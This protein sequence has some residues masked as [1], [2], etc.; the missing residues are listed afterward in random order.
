MSPNTKD[1]KK[2]PDL[3]NPGQM[4]EARKAFYTFSI[5]ELWVEMT[6]PF[7][8]GGWRGAIMR[9]GK[10]ISQ[11][12]VTKNMPK[13]RMTESQRNFVVACFVLMERVSHLL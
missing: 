2:I 3:A 4:I 1:R 8:Q 7:N 5:R 9:N 13:S 6:K 12:F 10:T 11:S